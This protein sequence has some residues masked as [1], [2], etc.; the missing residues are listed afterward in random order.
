M[1]TVPKPPTRCPQHR[2]GRL[3]P[4]RV[5]IHKTPHR[6]YPHHCHRIHPIRCQNPLTPRCHLH[7]S[8][9]K[10]S[11]RE[12]RHAHTSHIHAAE[13]LR[14]FPGPYHHRRSRSCQGPGC[15]RHTIGSRITTQPDRCAKP[16]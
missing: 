2:V 11:L 12:E 10:H 4:Q 3:R 15:R 5:R 13:I 1:S 9:Q 6:L 8:S 14:L 16:H 7:V